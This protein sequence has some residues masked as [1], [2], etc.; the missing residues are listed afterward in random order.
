MKEFA[1]MRKTT[2]YLSK[3][4]TFITA[5]NVVRKEEMLIIST[6]SYFYNVFRSLLHSASE[7]LRLCG[8]GLP[9]FYV[10]SLPNEKKTQTSN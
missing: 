2:L 1:S 8:K 7:N 6:F 4:I 5:G 10:D 9:L 3:A